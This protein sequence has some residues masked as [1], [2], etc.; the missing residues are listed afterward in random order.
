MA[1]H[2]CPICLMVCYCDCDDIPCPAPPVCIHECDPGCLE[3]DDELDNEDGWWD[4]DEINGVET[5][6]PPLD[7]PLGER[8][9]I[10]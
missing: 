10:A 1:Y 8:G 2:D 9:V 5:G 7:P 3:P 6:V 4:D